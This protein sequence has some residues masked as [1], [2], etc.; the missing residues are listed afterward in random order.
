V[1]STDLKATIQRNADEI[2][3]L[4]E[5]V[6]ETVQRRDVNAEGREAWVRACAEFHEKFD[7]LAFPGG[8]QDAAQRILA[9]DPYTIEAALCFFEIRPYFFR[10]GYMYG[11]LLRKT[12]RAT[13]D[14][15][16]AS[17]LKAVLDRDAAWRA[18]KGR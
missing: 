7:R 5:R 3:R 1:R 2:V 9:G 16:Q 17:R 12:K 15:A 8:Y 11:A 13:L 14:T 4:H 10:S 6:H 18:K